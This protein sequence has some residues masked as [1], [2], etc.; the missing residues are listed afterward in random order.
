MNAFE[1]FSDDC[2]VLQWNNCSFTEWQEGKASIYRRAQ[3]LFESE[4]SEQIFVQLLQKKRSIGYYWNKA[5]Q[6]SLKI[7]FLG[8]LICLHFLS[9][10]NREIFHWNILISFLIFSYAFF[11]VTFGNLVVHMET[12][13]DWIDG[14]AVENSAGER[15]DWLTRTSSE[16]WW[17][18]KVLAHLI[19]ME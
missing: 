5:W 1:W 6:V 16:D 14:W 2:S 8:I 12:F 13:P 10:S 15:R 4:K 3:K 19:W 17:Q 9:K 7:K 11:A 18:W